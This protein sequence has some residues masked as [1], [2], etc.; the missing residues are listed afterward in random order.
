MDSKSLISITY[1]ISVIIFILIVYLLYK[2]IKK[3]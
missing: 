1:I 2:F 3:L